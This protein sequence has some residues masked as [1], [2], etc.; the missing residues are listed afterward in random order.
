MNK[1]GSMTFFY[2]TFTS[3]YC[4]QALLLPFSFHMHKAMS[5]YSTAAGNSCVFFEPFYDYYIVKKHLQTYVYVH[6]AF[7]RPS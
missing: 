5:L 1:I 7:Y 4:S 2:E 3:Y 6:I